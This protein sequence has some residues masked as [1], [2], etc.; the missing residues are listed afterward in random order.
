MTQ[1]HPGPP[2][3]S[4]PAVRLLSAFAAAVLAAG[5]VD[6]PATA[7]AVLLL[8]SSPAGD[9]EA[10]AGI[11]RLVG[12]IAAGSLLT[13]AVA[14]L[15]VSV[16][17]LDVPLQ[18]AVGLGAALGGGLGGVGHLVA[19]GEETGDS[20]VEEVAVETGADAD[21]AGPTTDDLFAVHPDPVLYF[22]TENDALVARAVNP[23]FESR[24][25]ASATTLSGTPLTEAIMT[26]D[27]AAIVDRLRA[28]E[29][30]AESVTCE[31]VDGEATARLR[32]VP[33]D[34]AGRSGY[35]LYADVET[36]G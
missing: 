11:D 31:T 28:G 27:D 35:L 26:D 8:A 14:W 3:R 24:F 2:I 5:A 22:D 1:R 4:T 6:S 16:G 19:A 18:V 34:D 21:G 7:T 17:G 33:V 25:G 10:N 9:R 30:F 32:A 15:A 23:A 12:W 29:A 36:D 20:G 13:A